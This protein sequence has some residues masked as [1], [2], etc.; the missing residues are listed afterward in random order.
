MRK[1]I[2]ILLTMIAFSL[3]PVILSANF[4]DDTSYNDEYSWEM[5]D[6]NQKKVASGILIWGFFLCVASALLSAFI[7]N[8]TAPPA[9]PTPSTT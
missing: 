2:A 3:Q 6:S 9:A 7:P 1:K 5:N 8:S 4:T